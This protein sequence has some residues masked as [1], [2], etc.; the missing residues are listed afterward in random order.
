[1]KCLDQFGLSASI[2][3][4]SLDVSKLN[5]AQ[6]DQLERDDQFIWPFLGSFKSC[7]ICSIVSQCLKQDRNVEK[8]VS[9]NELLRSQLKR[10]DQELISSRETFQRQLA[11]ERQSFESRLNC[12]ADC[13]HAKCDEQHESFLAEVRRLKD[14][15]ARFSVSESMKRVESS[16]VWLDYECRIALK[17]SRRIGAILQLWDLNRGETNLSDEISA[18]KQ[19]VPFCDL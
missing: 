9:E 8:L 1:M 4:E 12:A 3:F 6:L 17:S 2:L 13:F 16:E 11:S 7:S 19:A 14:D 10:L 5:L 18:I 15:C